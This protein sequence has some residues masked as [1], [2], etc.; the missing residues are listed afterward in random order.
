MDAVVTGSGGHIGYHVA[1]HLL[2]RGFNV[3]LIIRSE[4]VNILQLQQSGAKIYYGNLDNPDTY[5]DVLRCKDVLFHLAAENTT[6]TSDPERV[7]KNTFDIARTVID[8][9]IA[10]EIPT[11]VYTSSVVV[12]GRSESSDILGNENSR[13][14]KPESPYVQGKLLAE[15]YCRKM[16]EK[17][18]DIRILYPSWVV[19]N[20]DIKGT[21]PH[22]LIRKYIKEGQKFYFEGGI[23]IA[24]VDDIAH[25]HVQVWVKGEKYGRYVLGGRNITFKEFYNN[26]ALCTGNKTPV[27]KLPKGVI[28]FASVLFKLLF[29]RKSPVDPAYVKAVVNR[30]SWYDSSRAIQYL[31][32]KIRNTSDI[33]RAGINMAGQQMLQ[34]HKLIDRRTDSIPV[35]YDPKDVLLI[36]GFPGWLSNRMVDIMINGDHFGKNKIKRK[37]RLL[38]HRSHNF[39]IHL[40]PDFEIIYGDINDKESLDKALQGVKTVYHI[41][42]VIYPK[43]IRQFYQVN[44]EGTRNLIDTCIDKKIRRII[45]MS[46]DSVCGYS[47][48][49]RI[50]SE[51][52]PPTPYKNYG[53]SKY[54]AESYIFEKTS[55]GLIDGTILRGFWFFGSFA[56][57][58]NLGFFR[59]FRWKYQPVFGN[60][61][62]YRTI[63]HIDNLVSAFI[64]AEKEPATIGKWYWIGDGS[65]NLTVNDIYKNIAA[66]LN[67]SF[68]PIY[69]PKFICDGLSLFDSLLSK[70]NLLNPTIHAAG[71]FHKNIAAKSD[72]AANDFGYLPEAGFKQI[73][74]EIKQYD[75]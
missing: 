60:G 11:I 66:A 55:A 28:V 7:I 22:K 24:H 1:R 67:K 48:S 45:F 5:K 73:A 6:D 58:R 54:M 52:E 70:F 29:G 9:A 21:P 30:F 37:I 72:R 27:L 74:E 65:G 18:V 25:A 40:P 8:T 43:K 31:D 39:D 53:K 3:H 33:T 15:D 4:N 20:N 44:Y 64:H 50:F 61:R 34:T 26:L 49:S 63:T 2:N 23:S 12:L 10:S 13:V 16:Q 17:G 68:N 56:P 57:E 19:G 47:P 14:Q 38:A 36:T 32:Y 42:G 59:M 41:A 75:I 69:I 35:N 46:T 62:N 71:K 51:N